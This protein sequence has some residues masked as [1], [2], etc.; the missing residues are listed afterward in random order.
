MD[1]LRYWSRRCTSTSSASTW[2]PHSRAGCTRW[3][4]FGPFFDLIQQDPVVSGIKL[5]AEPWDI[6]GGLPGRELPADVVGVER[7]V[8]RHGPGLLAWRA[9]D[10]RRVRLP[11]HRQLRP[12]RRR[13]EPGL[14]GQLRDGPRR[15]HARRPG[16]LQR[17]AQRRQPRRPRRREPQPAPGTAAPR[18]RPTTL[19]S[20]SCAA[21]RRN[22]LHAPVAVPRRAD[23]ARGRRDRPHPAGQQQRLLPGQR[24]RA[25]STG[26]SSIR[27]GPGRLRPRGSV[28]CARSTRCSGGDDGSP[29]ERPRRRGRRHRLVPPTAPRCRTPTGHRVRQRAGRPAQRR[30]SCTPTPAVV[31]SH[32]GTFLVLFNADDGASALDAAGACRARPATTVRCRHQG[33]GRSAARRACRAANLAPGRRTALG[34]PDRR[35]GRD[36]RPVT[37][38]RLQLRRRS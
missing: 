23:A 1:S 33:A 38:Y 4:A 30:A 31:P 7:P 37:T 16:Q 8:P 21:A 28:V 11:L 2:P 13:L 20:T 17:E 35:S 29:G 5:I 24:A 10:H 6:G 9:G 18:V 12:V 25:G 34:G 15:L 27:L 14:V 26:A 3:T 32:D 19:P 36:R 22:M